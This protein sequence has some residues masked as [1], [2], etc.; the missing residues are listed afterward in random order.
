MHLSNPFLPPSA[1]TGHRTH[2]VNDYAVS[3][4]PPLPRAS[5][6]TAPTWTSVSMIAAR[7]LEWLICSRLSIVHIDAPFPTLRFPL[8]QNCLQ[9]DSPPSS[10]HLYTYPL[11]N[12][13]LF[14]LTSIRA[15][16]PN[17]PTILLPVPPIPCPSR[18]PSQRPIIAVVSSLFTLGRR[19]SPM[20]A[21][22]DYYWTLG[23]HIDQFV[24]CAASPF[25]PRAF[26]FT[27]IAVSRRALTIDN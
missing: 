13:V 19:L 12:R 8:I 14:F 3:L 22:P 18:I 24:Y 11:H 23:Q 16:T 5:L 17:W 7:T 27:S 2:S 6:A 21:L 9:F 4:L 20:P 26:H 1:S 10:V 15:P 25:N